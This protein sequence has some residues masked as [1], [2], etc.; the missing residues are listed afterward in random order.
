VFTITYKHMLVAPTF[1]LV[2]VPTLL[3]IVAY[4]ALLVMIEMGQVLSDVQNSGVVLVRVL[5]P[6]LLLM[7]R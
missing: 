2:R 6:L 1:N 4:A 5:F 7:L 3:E